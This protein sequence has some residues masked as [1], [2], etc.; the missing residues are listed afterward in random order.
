M[1]LPPDTARF[2]PE[3]PDALVSAALCC[4]LCLHGDGVTWEGA[5]DAYDPS[6]ECRCPSC[7]VRWR[8]HL[9]PQ[10]ALRLGLLERCAGG[11]RLHVGRLQ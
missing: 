4:P 10:Q 8:V 9:E 3:D 7:Q 6:V 2:R 1:L 11:R 5:L